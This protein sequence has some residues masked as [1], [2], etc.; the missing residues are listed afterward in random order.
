MSDT[1]IQAHF[2][3][4]FA[5]K[6]RAALIAPHFKERLHQYAIGL[7]HAHGHQVLA[8]NTMPDHVHLLFRY[9]IN[10]TIPHLMQHL[11]RDTSRWINENKF[12]PGQFSWQAGYAALVVEPAR[13]GTVIHYIQN[14]EQHHRRQSMADEIEVLL[15][16]EGIRYDRRYGFQAPE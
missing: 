15:E 12:T 13:I 10:E 1:Y 14:Q 16:Q 4:V 2:H 5:V 3:V 9:N 6:K 11:K 8:F 7:I